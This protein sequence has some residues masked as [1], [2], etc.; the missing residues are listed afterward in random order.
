MANDTTITRSAER[1]EDGLVPALRSQTWEQRHGARRRAIDRQLL[2]EA[3]R[4]ITAEERAAPPADEDVRVRLTRAFGRPFGR[5][6]KV[7]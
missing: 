2:A 4:A 7:C 5:A 6:N 1:P 3:E